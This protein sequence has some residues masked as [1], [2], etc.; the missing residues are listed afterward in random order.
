MF[1]N[2]YIE[3]DFT[4]EFDLYIESL[5]ATTFYSTQGSRE[6]LESLRRIHDYIMSSNVY[7]DFSKEDVENYWT[8]D[9]G[10]AKS[11]KEQIIRSTFKSDAY[12]GLDRKLSVNRNK[13]KEALPNFS[14]FTGNSFEDSTIKSRELGGIFL[15]K[16]FNEI[17]FFLNHSF[18]S[19]STGSSLSQIKELGHPCSGLVIIDKHLF[20][21]TKNLESK[22]PNLI[23]VI[24]WLLPKGLSEKF[25]ICIISENTESKLGS[26]I[27]SR[28]EE[29]KSYFDNKISLQVYAP[30]KLYEIEASDRFLLSNYS[31]ISI[32]HPF[33]RPTTISCNFYPSHPEDF[34]TDQP[35]KLG[36]MKV[37]NGFRTWRSK[38][39]VAK[40]VM[41]RTPSKIGT[42][43]C[44]WKSDELLHKIFS[45]LNE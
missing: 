23:N 22:I 37:I 31:L 13:E 24:D 18:S 12:S 20:K 42:V 30:I 45:N 1:P 3:D 39:E 36:S 5:P 40:V 7:S 6:K 33:D 41:Y 43:Q 9:E 44:S 10:V 16:K 38:L 19:V 29:I 21:D 4:K 26:S 17:P 34:S 27:S 8:S 15:G 14:F 11:F 35:G 28:F 25:E 2:V 32:P